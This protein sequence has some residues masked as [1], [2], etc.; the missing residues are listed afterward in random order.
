MISH[1]VLICI[2]LMISNVEHFFNSIQKLA[3]CM[4][5]LGNVTSGPLP[6]FLTRLF[7]DIE[8]YEFV[9]NFGY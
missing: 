8:L 6:I 9:A 1:M 3:I 4:T 5:S 7:P 2:S